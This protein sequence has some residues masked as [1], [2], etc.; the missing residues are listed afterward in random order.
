MT[1]QAFWFWVQGKWALT[2]LRTF[3]KTTE[4][5]PLII[6]L[7]ILSFCYNFLLEPFQNLG[8]EFRIERI[9]LAGFPRSQVNDQKRDNHHK[10]QGDDLLNDAPTDE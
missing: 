4:S 10:K 9:H 7:K 3:L 2:L 6:I 5:P 1:W 8:R